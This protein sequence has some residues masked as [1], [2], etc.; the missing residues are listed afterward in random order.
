MFPLLFAL[1]CPSSAQEA[2]PKGRVPMEVGLRYRG[3]KVPEGIL[4]IWAYDENDP[5]EPAPAERPQARAMAFGLEYS[6]R[7]PDSIWT[8][9]VERVVSRT[10]AGYW[11]D[12]DD[13]GAIDH[14]DG[15]WIVPSDD[16]GAVAFGAD[17]AR[18]FAV[19]NRDKPVWLGIDVGGG[20]GLAVVTGELTRWVV[21]YNLATVDVLDPTCLPDAPAYER[22]GSCGDDGTVRIPSVVPMVDINV[23]AKLNF[24]YGYVRLEGGL[25]DMLYWGVA[26]GGRF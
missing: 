4:D 1:V 18:A 26:G 13:E 24:P 14:L 21:G 5:Q 15:Q 23:G 2:A 19:T 12:V 25:H 9:Y 7:M 10:G 11:D 22:V 6:L 20:L 17:T 16:F 3:M 8:F